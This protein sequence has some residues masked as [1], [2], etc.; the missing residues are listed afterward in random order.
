MHSCGAAVG[1]TVLGPIVCVS[2]YSS[3]CTVAL[4][5]QDIFEDDVISQGLDDE[6]ACSVMTT[7]SLAGDEHDDDIMF[8][9]FF[10][11][12]LESDE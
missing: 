7:E 11:L 8:G 12:T 2:W 10:D 3:Q 9:N 5:L 6:S 4:E 1:V